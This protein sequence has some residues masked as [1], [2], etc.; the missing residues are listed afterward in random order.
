ME[1]ERVVRV[2]EEREGLRFRR[3][4]NQF[5]GFLLSV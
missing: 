2:L 5:V 4:V 3:E 1:F